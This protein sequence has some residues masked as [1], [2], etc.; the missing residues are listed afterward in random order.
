MSKQQVTNNNEQTTNK[1]QSLT[2]NQQCTLNNDNNSNNNNNKYSTRMEIVA[3]RDIDQGDE[4]THAY[5]D[6]VQDKTTRQTH[7]QQLHGFLCTCRRCQGH[8]TVHL[9][10]VPP[11]NLYEWIVQQRNPCLGTKDSIDLQQQQQQHN[12]VPWSVDEAL[13]NYGACAGDPATVMT[14]A[15]LCLQ[16]SQQHMASNNIDKEIA[17]L[18]HAL[19]L[20]DTT[21]PPLSKDLYQVRGALLSALLVLAARELDSDQ[22]EPILQEAR[23]T[24]LAMVAFL[25]VA[26]PENHPLLGLQLFTLGDLTEDKTVHAWA[27][28]V[29]RTSHGKHHDLVRR[30]DDILES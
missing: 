5:V 21:A 2:N 6:L 16:E 14:Q 11:D 12:L 24:C 26:L 3:L 28:H 10:T 1:E 8:V 4:L 29:L 25:T 20:L 7:L 15:R 19:T 27:R 22:Q 18:R 23:D 9:P 13:C 17:T 30:L